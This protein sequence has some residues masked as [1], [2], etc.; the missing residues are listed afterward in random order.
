MKAASI[1]LTILILI[2]FSCT[3]F[4]K[5]Q[6][7]YFHGR[8]TLDSNNQIPAKNCNFTIYQEIDEMK[9]KVESISDWY[10][11][12][13]GYY[14]FYTNVKVYNSF[15]N[16]FMRVS[17]QIIIDG[18]NRPFY[19]EVYTTENGSDI[20]INYSIFKNQ[21]FK[22]HFKNVNPFND[23]D[24]ISR[25]QVFEEQDDMLVYEFYTMQSLVG[26]N[27]DLIFDKTLLSNNPLFYK[28]TVKK[29]N[30]ETTSDLIAMPQPNCV[31]T[32]LMD[33]FY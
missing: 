24:Y 1:F 2:N 4:D 11:D 25:F 33:V 19:G 6:E 32:V 3:K 20:E 31:D 18:Q 15:K 21:N 10:T 14:G 30:I 22:F 16:Y 26:V 17:D 12:D 7:V 9:N 8:I 27:V 28:Y 29:N 13:D 5:S 23:F